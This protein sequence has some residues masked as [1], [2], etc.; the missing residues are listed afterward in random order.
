MGRIQIQPQG[1]VRWVGDRRAD[2]VTQRLAC[3]KRHSEIGFLS[4][5]HHQIGVGNHFLP[6]HQGQSQKEHLLRK[7]KAFRHDPYRRRLGAGNQ[8]P[9]GTPFIP[10]S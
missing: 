10:D 5:P 9:T 2:P 3:G 4:G 1:Q 6:A 7:R 8:H